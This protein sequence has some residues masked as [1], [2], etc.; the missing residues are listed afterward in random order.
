MKRIAAALGL[1]LSLS[2]PVFADIT[3]ENKTDRPLDIYVTDGTNPAR[4]YTIT[5]SEKITIP[6]EHGGVIDIK[7]AGGKYNKTVLATVK[8]SGQETIVAT[9]DK[10][11]KLKVSKSRKYW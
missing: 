3:F 9:H 2:A 10:D 5:N 7:Y 6:A 8:H 4:S 11:G 1:L